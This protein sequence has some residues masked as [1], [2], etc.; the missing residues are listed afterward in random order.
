MM[1]HILRILRDRWLL[2]SGLF[3]L[4]LAVLFYATTAHIR[5]SDQIVISRQSHFVDLLRERGLVADAV[6]VVKQASVDMVRHRHI[7]TSERLPLDL[8][9]AASHVTVIEMAAPLGD[10][11]LRELRFYADVESTYTVRKR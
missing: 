2:G 1:T 10:L 4:W 7:I 6:Q 8:M 5:A 11:P 9:A 3:I